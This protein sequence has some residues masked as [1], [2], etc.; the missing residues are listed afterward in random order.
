[1]EKEIVYGKHVAGYDNRK[2]YAWI[3]FEMFQP[4]DMVVVDT[5]NG[6]AVAR[7]TRCEPWTDGRTAKRYVIGK[8]DDEQYAQQIQKDK[9]AASLKKKLD[10]RA[11]K[12][13][14]ITL[15]EMLSEDD[16]EMQ[17]LLDQYKALIV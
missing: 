14:D 17:E 9:L 8:V 2:E 1:M 10:A 6:Y 4:G 12:L 13:Q 3:G 5:C 15:Y 7:V 11:K 16:P